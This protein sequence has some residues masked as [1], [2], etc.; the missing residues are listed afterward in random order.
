MFFFSTPTNK[1]LDI[2][3]ERMWQNGPLGDLQRAQ[4]T[5]SVLFITKMRSMSIT[6]LAKRNVR[7]GQGGGKKLFFKVNC[8]AYISPSVRKWVNVD[9]LSHMNESYPIKLL[10]LQQSVA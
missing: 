2:G 10:D 6:K 4:W 1:K 3:L 7:R 5:Q 9:G 8:K